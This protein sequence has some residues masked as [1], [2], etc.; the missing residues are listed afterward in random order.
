MRFKTSK[1]FEKSAKK[2]SGK[3]KESLKEM[4]LEIKQVESVDEITDCKKLIGYNNIYRIRL[5]DYRTFFFFEI[6]EQ[7]VYLKYL[8]RRGEAYN[9][10]YQEKL[11]NADKK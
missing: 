7:T 4:I 3:Y 2:L 5:G 8:V 1:E 10:A 11:K 9:K 6:V